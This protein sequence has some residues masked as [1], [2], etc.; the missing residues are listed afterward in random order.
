ML[1]I[2]YHE[3]KIQAV[4]GIN[5]TYCMHRY[6]YMYAYRFET[7]CDSHLSN[8]ITVVCKHRG[9]FRMFAARSRKHVTRNK[10]GKTLQMVK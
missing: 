9:G 8:L 7:Q 3:G 4:T 5:N 10:K 1:Q 6:M 2:I